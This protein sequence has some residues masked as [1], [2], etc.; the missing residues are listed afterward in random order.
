MLSYVLNLGA[1]AGREDPLERKLQLGLVLVH[2]VLMWF[3][4]TTKSGRNKGRKEAR[5]EGRREQEKKGTR[6]GAS[7]PFGPLARFAVISRGHQKSYFSIP[8][9]QGQ[10]WFQFVVRRRFYMSDLFYLSLRRI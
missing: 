7:R 1:G 5:K 9:A 10:K 3:V 2:G 4:L 8:R 6:E